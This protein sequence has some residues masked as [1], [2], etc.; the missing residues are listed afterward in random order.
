MDDRRFDRMARVLGRGAS[1]RE[2]LRGIGG[3]AT[4]VAGAGLLARVPALAQDE[5]P[6]LTP[7]QCRKA[8][9]D[10]AKVC[11]QGCAGLTSKEKNACLKACQATRATQR[12]A[13][14]T[15]NGG[16]EDDGGAEA[17]AA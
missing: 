3:V 4:G 13:C 5:E 2:V 16:G 11:R 17:P 7:R 10:A 14:G 15:G 9:N 8:A 1:R 6:V 12:A